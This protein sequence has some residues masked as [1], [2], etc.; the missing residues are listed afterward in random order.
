MNRLLGLLTTLLLLTLPLSSTSVAAQEPSPAA[1]PARDKPITVGAELVADTLS[2]EMR[3]AIEVELP[4][5]LQELGEVHGFEVA[6]SETSTVVV[7]VDIGQ[8]DVRKPVYLLHSSVFHGGELVERAE[9]QTC[10]RCTAAEIV[11]RCLV[12]LPPAVAQVAALPQAEPVVEA[13]PPVVDAEEIGAP[14]TVI[15]RRPGPLVPAGLSLA[16]IGLVGTIAGGVLLDK[17]IQPGDPYFLT[18]INYRKPGAVLFGI[19]LSS[20][21]VGIVLVALDGWDVGPRSRR[22]TRARDGLGIGVRF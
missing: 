8:S 20:M 17:G 10:V 4:K 9:A 7:Y 11:S 12:L 21:V 5:Q 6:Q 1:A 13:P 2:D 19:G 3:A 22:V 14:A 15:R 18:E 16:G